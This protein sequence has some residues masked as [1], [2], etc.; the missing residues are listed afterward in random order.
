MKIHNQ[1]LNVNGDGD[2]RYEK[3]AVAIV[4]QAIKDYTFKLKTGRRN[5]EIGSAKALESFFLSDWGQSLSHGHGEEII[6]RV[7]ENIKNSKA[8][9][10]ERR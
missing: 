2:E 3:L 6:R 4:V 10:N 8:V 5:K 9:R 1:V 7:K